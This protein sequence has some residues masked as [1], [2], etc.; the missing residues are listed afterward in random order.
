MIL[1]R[2]FLYVHQPKTGGTFVTTMLA[3]AYPARLPRRAERGLRRALRT[4]RTPARHTLAR[5]LLPVLGRVEADKH[6][7]CHDIPEAWRRARLVATVRD[8]ID[9]YTSIYEFGWWRRDDRPRPWLDDAL[10]RYPTFPDITFGEFMRIDRARTR[11]ADLADRIPASVGDQT[12]EFVDYFC[13]HPLDTLAALADLDASAGAE[14]IRA[15]LFPVR[16]LDT[17]VLNEDLAALLADC[18]RPR[19]TVDAVRAATPVR[20]PAPTLRTKDPASYYDR[21]LLDETAH[22]ERYLLALLS[23]VAGVS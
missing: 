17:S 1:T 2:D 10:R 19:Q 8:P 22:R 21:D 11:F 12:I 13:R 23:T 9:R 6:G 5:A 15:D 14:A 20:P 18:G 4:P 7:T 3:A 16:F